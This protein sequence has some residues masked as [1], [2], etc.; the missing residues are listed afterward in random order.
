MRRPFEAMTDSTAK[1]IDTLLSEHRTFTPPEE[2]V[3]QANVSD[4]SI[5]ENADADFQ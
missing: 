3:A 1:T 2:F 5:Y 4:P